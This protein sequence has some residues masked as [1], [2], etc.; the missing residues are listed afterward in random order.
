[1]ADVT[2]DDMSKAK[3]IHFSENNIYL[4]RTGHVRPAFGSQRL[5]LNLM[6]GFAESHLFQFMMRGMK[7]VWRWRRV[8]YGE[9]LLSAKAVSLLLLI[10][11]RW[12]GRVKILEGTS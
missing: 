1:M 12:F 2:K 4:H 11:P 5:S 8:C 10:V 9:V 6:Q 7:A 3:H